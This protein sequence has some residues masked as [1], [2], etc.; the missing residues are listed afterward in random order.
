LVAFT[1]FSSASSNSKPGNSFPRISTIRCLSFLREW[2]YAKPYA[3]SEER[4]AALPDWVAAY[5]TKRPYRGIGG[6][7]PMSR[8]APFRNNLLQDNS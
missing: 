7:T 1:V 2:A 5:N 3:T 6:A 4:A 8:L